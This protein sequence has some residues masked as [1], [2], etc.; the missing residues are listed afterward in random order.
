M[1]DVKDNLGN[2]P[3]H[4]ACEEDRLSTAFYLLEIGADPAATNRG[5]VTHTSTD[6]NSSFR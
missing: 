4:M 3:L 2:T 5:T 1:V 6:R